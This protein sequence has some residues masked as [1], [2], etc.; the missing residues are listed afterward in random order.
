MQQQHRFRVNK[1]QQLPDFAGDYFSKSKIDRTGKKIVFQDSTNGI[2]SGYLDEMIVEKR[3]VCGEEIYDFDL[4]AMEHSITEED[5][6]IIVT[7]KNAP[8]QLKNLTDGMTKAT[9]PTIDQREINQFPVATAAS[10]DGKRIAAGC[11]NGTISLFETAFENS[12]TPLKIPSVKGCISHLSFSAFTMNSLFFAAYQEGNIFGLADLRCEEAPLLC[13][14]DSA[15]SF[16]IYTVKQVTEHLLLTAVRRSSFID[17]WDLRMMQEK[18]ASIPRAVPQT[19]QK[20]HFDIGYS[21]S[22]NVCVV[23]G[24]ANG[25]LSCT[26]LQTLACESIPLSS[27]IELP[28]PTVSLAWN[29][30]STFHCVCT[31]G[32]RELNAT[33]IYSVT[34]QQQ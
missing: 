16:G 22:G 31:A 14:D 6:S 23:A 28:I 4:V 19:F 1:Q 13:F 18:V 7:S 3:F 5:S 32:T 30:P 2:Y 27:N 34:I 33:C 12:C 25:S 29:S 26:D 21:A 8:L 20:M 24:D 9:Y 15:A 17:C 11:T 10:F